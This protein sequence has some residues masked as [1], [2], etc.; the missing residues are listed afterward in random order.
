[1]KEN[2]YNDSSFF[3]KYS[4]MSRSVEGLAGAG[5]WD[6]LK[7]MLPSFT[8]KQVL[9]LGCGFGWHCR[10]A[11]EQGATHVVG[12]DIS[13]KMLEV[14]KQKTSNSKIEY[15]C[16]PIEDVDLE[17]QHFDI[18]LSSL[19]FHYLNTDAFKAVC[20]DVYRSL[21]K[22]GSFIFSIEHPVFTASGEQDWIYDSEKEISH[23]PVD[24]YFID[25]KRDANFLG[26]EITKYHRSLTTYIQILLN[27]GFVIKDIVEPQPNQK[28]LEEIDG[29]ENELRRPMMMI[30]SLLK[31]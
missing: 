30:I 2:K 5:E 3:D 11:V 10:Y 8:N 14:A 6:A 17:G 20:E 26:E 31:K 23:W 4:Q 22:D 1:M 25:G 29:M 16:K 7:A 21:N 13:E 27:C 19:A 18:I 24:H 28:M 15:I 12:V 9:D